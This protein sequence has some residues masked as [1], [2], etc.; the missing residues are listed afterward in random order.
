MSDRG[1]RRAQK[2]RNLERWRRHVRTWSATSGSNPDRFER[3]A[4]LSASH[5]KLC[6][7]WMCG[8]P[9]RTEDETL[10]ERRAALRATDRE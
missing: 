10:Q 8:N 6:S 7:C 2:M 4:K 3:T 5:G 1:E 9:R